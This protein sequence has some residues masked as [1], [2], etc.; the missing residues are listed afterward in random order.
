MKQPFT[1]RLRLCFAKLAVSMSD[2]TPVMIAGRSMR[3]PFEPLS[4]Q[5]GVDIEKDVVDILHRKPEVFD[6]QLIR[7]YRSS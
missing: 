3:P 7:Q 1:T 2:S 6:A 4:D 5:T